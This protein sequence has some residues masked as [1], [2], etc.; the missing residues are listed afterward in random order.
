MKKEGWEAQIAESDND[1]L[2]TT[3]TSLRTRINM[4]DICSIGLQIPSETSFLLVTTNSNLLIIPFFHFQSIMPT[5]TKDMTKAS[6][7]SHADTPP[8]S[9]GITAEYSSDDIYKVLKVIADRLAPKTTSINDISLPPPPPKE[10]LALDVPKVR[11]SNL[12]YRKVHE[13]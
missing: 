12:P 8:D 3:L 7:P 2:L 5:Q 13:M 11:A 1:V 6:K 10:P 4:H 9:P